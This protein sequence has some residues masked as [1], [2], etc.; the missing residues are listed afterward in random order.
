MLG[1]KG[2]H[3]MDS[4]EIDGVS[5][6]PSIAEHF[7]YK[8]QILHDM[9]RY[10]MQNWNDISFGE[11]IVKASD[12]CNDYAKDC[13]V[14]FNSERTQCMCIWKDGKLFQVYIHMEGHD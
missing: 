3:G 7:M 1:F 12:I 8:C 6:N 13:S 9:A 5:G 10:Q 11:G 2:L 4:H 14:K